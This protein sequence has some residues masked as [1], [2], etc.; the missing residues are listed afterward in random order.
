MST[1]ATTRVTV[2]NDG[3]EVDLGLLSQGVVIELRH[4]RMA[5]VDV[6]SGDVIADLVIGRWTPSSRL[7]SRPEDLLGYRKLFIQN[8]APKD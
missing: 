8:I 2:A 7:V 1:L 4:G 3:H 6:A 5:A